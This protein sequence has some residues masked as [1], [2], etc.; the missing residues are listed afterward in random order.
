M[1]SMGIII[2]VGALLITVLV[3]GG[4]FFTLYKVFGG[5]KK[6]SQ[7][8]DRLLREGVPAMARVTSVQMGG[9]TMTVG[10]HR[11]LQ[12][13]IGLEVHPQGQPPYAAMLTT[14]VS[15]LQIPQIQPGV[16]VTVRFDRN[17]PS[18]LALEGVGGAM[19]VPGAPPGYGQPGPAQAYG[20]PG[21]VA[22]PGAIPGYAGAP[23][24]AAYAQPGAGYAPVAMQAVQG[25]PAMPKGAK[26][27]LIIG[28][29][30]AVVGIGVAVVVVAI[31]V[32]DV[33]SDSTAS[34]SGACARAARCCETI[35]GP[36]AACKNYGRVGVPESACQTALDG[37]Q[38][39]ASAQ[40][41]S[42]N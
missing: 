5:L 17:D 19:G 27:G 12:L 40:G 29:I 21:Q 20:Y 37:Y 7:E 18:K 42:C 38:T 24:V 10:V 39:A 3:V 26:I 25:V 28:L 8:R 31:T 6:A 23:G 16:T 11:H 34:G 32:F 30:G 14:M 1:D 15:E 13:Q 36:A 2:T 22:A 4:V 41:K 35:G 33:G 9:M